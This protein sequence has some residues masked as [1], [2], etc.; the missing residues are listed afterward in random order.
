[1]AQRGIGSGRER[2]GKGPEPGGRGVLEQPLFRLVGL[3]ANRLK[4]TEEGLDLLLTPRHE[5]PH[6]IAVDDRPQPRARAAVS[7][8][9]VRRLLLTHRR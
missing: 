1:M 5:R 2:T 9:R 6:F 7:G 3:S 8:N 4:L